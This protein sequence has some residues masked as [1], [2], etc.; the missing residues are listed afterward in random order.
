VDLANSD[1]L[2]MARAV[3]PEGQRTIG[4]LTKLDLMDRGTSAGAALGNA[5]VPLRLGYV[6]VVSRSQHDIQ[7]G[8]DIRLALAEADAWFRSR[9]EYAE[10]LDRCGVAALGRTINH[11]LVQHIHSLLPKLKT[12]VEA[13][14][15]RKSK[16]LAGY[17]DPAGVSQTSRGGLLLKLVTDY[18][19][20]FCA[21]LDGKNEDMPTNEL[22]GGA[23]IR[24]IF[25]EIFAT[26]LEEL[27]PS[28]DLS[29]AEI[30]TAIQNS[31]GVGG[32]LMIPEAPFEILVRT[33]IRKLLSPALQCS[34]LVHQELLRIAAACQNDALARFP[35]LQKELDVA[36]SELIA[37]GAEPCEAMLR[38]LVD[39]ELAFINTSHPEFIGGAQ[40]VALV[41]DRR[42]AAALAGP[43]ES[44]GSGLSVAKAM[45]Q[46]PGGVLGAVPPRGEDDDDG[47]EAE[48]SF[49]DA[50]GPS[51]GA[52]KAV[53]GGEPGQVSAPPPVLQ[54]GVGSEQQGIE[55]EVTRLLVD[56]YHAIVRGT[57]QDLA[58][59]AIMQFLVG[60]MTRG[61]H[62][63]LIR[64][65]YRE[66]RLEHLMAESPEV[67]VQRQRC[68]DAVTALTAALQAL[69][70][71]PRDL[72]KRLGVARS[73]AM[74]AGSLSSAPR[75]GHSAP[76]HRAAPGPREQGGL[77]EAP[78]PS[79]PRGA[80]R[81]GLENLARVGRAG[82]KQAGSV[83]DASLAALSQS[84]GFP[85]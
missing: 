30:R 21:T 55:V 80:L 68:H 50:F 20:R 54:V 49:E 27:D 16:E 24:H 71:I 65:L 7:T 67:L 34:D 66:D 76:R 51:A 56:S 47:S 13:T 46:Q 62:Q 63:H 33:A 10:V 78:A 60:N 8:K 53:G 75:G 11:I 31:G 74:P 58:P 36:V 18:H 4:V 25:Q 41:I 73:V 5:V 83:E 1:A 69:D 40:A 28:R 3:D 61:L 44:H 29:D 52:A 45:A 82:R 77:T 39:C 14:L 57:L 9:P 19:E 64:T 38:N 15:Q 23:R 26:A 79:P 81:G 43:S 35:L 32:S 37:A 22:A 59:K 70:T 6:G 72:Q 17:G 85:E 42:R 2:Q 48:G 12:K 84:T